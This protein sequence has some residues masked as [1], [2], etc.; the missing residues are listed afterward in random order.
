MLKIIKKMILRI[1]HDTMKDS[2]SMCNHDNAYYFHENAPAYC[3]SCK[4]YI[5]GGREI[6]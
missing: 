3:P 1:K 5:D 2:D 4:E 6:C